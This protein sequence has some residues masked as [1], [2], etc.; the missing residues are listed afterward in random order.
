VAYGSH[1]NFAAVNVNGLVA[2]PPAWH[3]EARRRGKAWPP[4]K[5][6][7]QAARVGMSTPTH[8][9]VDVE[10]GGGRLV[11]ELG[12]RTVPTHALVDAA[13]ELV[14]VLRKKELPDGRMVE[15]LMNGMPFKGGR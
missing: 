4:R 1:V 2:H 8:A 5:A 7:E 15:D 11:R 3:P 10:D 9:F 6:T 12:L 13:G 14:A